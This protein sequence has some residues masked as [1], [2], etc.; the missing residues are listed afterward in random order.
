MRPLLVEDE[1]LT[2]RMLAKGLREQA[3]AVDVAQ[4]AQAAAAL[5]VDHDYDLI[6]LDLGLP[7][8]DGLALCRRIREAGTSA[9]ILILTARDAVDSRIAGLDCGADD[10][11]LKPFDFG[12][13]LARL[14]ALSRRGGRP[15]QHERLQVGEL[16][17]DTRAQAA[18]CGTT[19][20]P[21]TTREYA[22]LEFMARRAGRVVARDDIAEHVWDSS[23]DPFSNVIDVYVRR[24]RAKLAATRCHDVI[25]TRRGA[26][27]LLSAEASEQDS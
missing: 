23:Y 8:L 7:D 9:P 21:L 27:Y 24:L 18:F 20:L 1:P 13:L 4:T 14:R 3:Y 16:V 12:E 10:Y 2:V 25:Q 22:L 15:P 19:P 17:L 6:V 5:V 26:G 11:L